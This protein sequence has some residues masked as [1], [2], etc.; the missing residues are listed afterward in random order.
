MLRPA[1]ALIT[2]ALST[3]CFAEQR[4]EWAFI[5]PTPLVTPQGAPTRTAA[6]EAQAPCALCHLPNGAGH[7]ESALPAG[8]P[9]D[10]IIRQFAEFRSGERRITPF[11][12]S[13]RT[14]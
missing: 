5:V 11:P 2:I 7:V 13:T 10:Y 3:S 9:A 4:P 8:L 14:G 12:S 1:A 6:P